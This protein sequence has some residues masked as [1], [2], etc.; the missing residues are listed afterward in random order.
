MG[1]SVAGGAVP[2]SRQK[3]CTACVLAKRRCDRRTPICKRCADKNVDCVYARTTVST[4]SHLREAGNAL[5]AY[6]NTDGLQFGG[7]TSSTF[8][9]SP[10]PPLDM[11]Y[12]DFMPMDSQALSSASLSLD[13]SSLDATNTGDLPTDHFMDMLDN[14][15]DPNLHQTLVSTEHGSTIDR[16]SSPADEGTLAAYDKMAPICGPVEPWMVHDPKTPLYYV[17]SRVK[18]FA[19]DAATRNA[20]PFMHRYLYRDHMPSCILECFTAN[21]LYAN[22]NPANMAMV[23]RALHR[24]VGDLVRTEVAHTGA[25]VTAK[26]A[27][28]QALFLYQVIR[29]FDG[30]VTLRAQ[31]EA[32]IP[33][34]QSWLGELCRV[35]EN[36]GDLADLED[37]VAR[38]QPPKKWERWI[39]AESLRRT[40]I[41]AYSVITLYQMMKNSEGSEDQN[42]WAYTHRWTISRH[43]WEADTS[44][45]FFRMWKEKPHYVI[46]NY[47]F[48]DFLKYGRG[49]DVDEFAE[50]LLSVYVGVDETKEFLSA[51]ENKT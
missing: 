3:N 15:I 21:M 27:R 35:R 6:M 33:L 44:F 7:S 14:C 34:L 42:P 31:G 51:T 16:P 36:L 46:N 8:S 2:A 13:P 30:D 39:F 26:L 28:T 11:D 32:D 12:L 50:I 22:R 48:D 20:T 45:S 47:A 29:L 49:D 9:L 19:S 25:T 43:L 10:G 18:G 23:M 37:S 1:R 41:M 38:A 5:P 24:N 40:I 4:S 17:I